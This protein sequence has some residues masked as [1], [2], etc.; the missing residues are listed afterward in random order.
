MLY[1]I[2]SLQ[3]SKNF[4]NCFSSYEEDSVISRY[5][6]IFKYVISHKYFAQ[7]LVIQKLENDTPI[8][9]PAYVNEPI[10]KPIFIPL[11][12]RVSKLLS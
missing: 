9:K 8:V 7:S 2:V 3:F 1:A 4:K 6:Y 5:D 12:R 11:F 10:P